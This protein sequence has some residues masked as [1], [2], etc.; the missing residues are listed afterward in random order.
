MLLRLLF[1]Y[2]ILLISLPGYAYYDKAKATPVRAKITFECTYSGNTFTSLYG[3]DRE[4]CINYNKPEAKQCSRTPFNRLGQSDEVWFDG[5]DGFLHEYWYCDFDGQ[6]ITYKSDKYYN[7]VKAIAFECP[8]SHPHGPQH[9]F[10]F[11]PDND[12][13]W[14]RIC[15]NPQDF[16]YAP[17]EWNAAQSDCVTYWPPDSPEFDPVL[18]VFLAKPQNTPNQCD[19]YAGNPINIQTGEKV[20]HFPPDLSVG[21][22][23]FPIQLTRSYYSFVNPYLHRRSN[24]GNA[25]TQ[26]NWI[27]H[28]QPNNYK[29]PTVAAA[30]YDLEPSSAG[31][32][33][34]SHN[35]NQRIIKKD[36]RS[37]LYRFSPGKNE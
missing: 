4:R 1:I 9:D 10:Y 2:L 26:S 17:Y 6:T 8:S 24:L 36:D 13:A 11:G 5:H 32:V 18:G 19:L 20:Q 35:Y 29:G 3:A 14:Q 23:A 25:T 7:R 37:V 12:R 27:M 21:D 30:R 16:C 28:R 34:M 22:T 31:Q 33:Y 15:Y